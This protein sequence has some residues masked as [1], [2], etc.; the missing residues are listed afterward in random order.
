MPAIIMGETSRARPGFSFWGDHWN[1]LAGITCPGDTCWNSKWG[2]IQLCN[3]FPSLH[4]QAAKPWEGKDA[5]PQGSSLTP[6]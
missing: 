1:H 5:L 3:P 6:G 2:G 4:L